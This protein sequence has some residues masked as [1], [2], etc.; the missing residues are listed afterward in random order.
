MTWKELYAAIDATDRLDDEA[1][2][3]LII[4]GVSESGRI[5]LT[6]DFAVTDFVHGMHT[7]RAVV[8]LNPEDRTLLRQLYIDDSER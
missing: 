8:Q 7:A 3:A 5:Q 1:C 4:E 2:V 6:S